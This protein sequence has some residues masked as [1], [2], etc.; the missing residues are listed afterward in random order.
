MGKCLLQAPEISTEG[1][2]E[3]MI[4]GNATATCYCYPLTMTMAMTVTLTVR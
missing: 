3:A 1:A 2:E 4:L